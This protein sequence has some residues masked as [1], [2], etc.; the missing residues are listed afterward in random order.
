MVRL[1]RAVDKDNMSARDG[2]PDPELLLRQV[3]A[4]ERSARRGRL[5]V[6]LGYSSGVG[7]TFSMLDE[8]SRHHQ[9]GQDVVVAAIQD[10]RPPETDGLL[11]VLESVPMRR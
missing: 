6:F 7:K 3:Q 5:K 11:S 8:G 9:R 1:H 4:E 10:K 2:R